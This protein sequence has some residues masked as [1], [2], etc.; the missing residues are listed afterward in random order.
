MAKP[1]TA[2]SNGRQKLDHRSDHKQKHP[3]IY[4]EQIEPDLRIMVGKTSNYHKRKAQHQSSKF[5]HRVDI[6]GLCVIRG[7]GQ[8]E[9]AIKREF[10]DIQ[11]DSRPEVFLP[12]TRLVDYVRWLRDQ[13]YAWLPDDDH[14]PPIDE[15][16]EVDFSVWRPS[17][18]RRKPAPA[19]FFPGLYGPLNLPPREI[20]GDDFYTNPLV[21]KAA[22]HAMGG[23]DLDPA[24]HAVANREV[25]AK[26]FYTIADDGLSKPWSGRVWLNPPFSQWSRWVPKIL[27]EWGSGRI[28]SMCALSAM[29]T[30]TAHYFGPLM[31]AADAWCVIRGRIRF[32]GGVAGDAPDDGHGVFYFGGD[33]E[34]FRVAFSELGAVYFKP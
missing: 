5:H 27:A 11:W 33:R 24:S 29:R 21:I 13:Y 18:E 22:V 28:E 14:C 15:M 32:W 6:T 3:V 9:D 23:I 20:T 8:C 12:D 4:F 25:K 10:S 2:A 30:V 17:P 26:R 1:T 19:G 16:D 31:L 7:T 34:R